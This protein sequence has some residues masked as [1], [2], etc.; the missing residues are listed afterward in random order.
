[1]FNSIH[2]KNKRLLFGLLTL[3]LLNVF[4]SCEKDELR[5]IEYPIDSFD[6]VPVE[7]MHDQ[8]VFM[9]YMP[10]FE[11]KESNDGTWGSHW[12]MANQNPDIIDAEGNRQI[13]SHYYP[14]IGPYHSGDKSVIEYHLLLMKY[15]GIDGV[16]IDW[17]GTFDVNDYKINLE[18]TEALI[19]LIDKV[20][21]KF[22]IVY[23]DRTLNPV[24]D[25]GA[26][27]SVE[28]AAR[29][30]MQYLQNNYFNHPSYYF[31]EGKP[32]LLVFGPD[33]LKSEQEWTNVFSNLN[34]KPSFL[35]LAGLSASVGNTRSGEFAWIF[36]GEQSKEDAWYQNID[37]IEIPMGSAYPG[38][39]DFY[40]EG[41]YGDSFF[42]MDHN[43]GVTLDS[44]LQRVKNA[45][46]DLVQL[47]TWNDY[48]EGTI[49]EPTK[50]FGFSYLEKIRDFNEVTSGSNNIFQNIFDLYTKRVENPNDLK[51]QSQLDQAF[52]YFVSMQTDKAIEELYK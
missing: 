50:E 1:M 2:M 35:P 7:K 14:L 8:A 13:A 44:K 39:H 43:N 10:W 23:E 28:N 52:Y 31:V 37:D 33:R 40:N 21:L 36:D 32:L 5:T 19:E 6:P 46:L 27:G 51:F 4:L 34:P 17:Y 29:I 42:F 49:L 41:G 45:N 38:F 12:T 11:T 3:L 9:H 25:A 15:A 48:G 20:G 47:V 22:A 16:L 30:D 24:V 26:A 18:N